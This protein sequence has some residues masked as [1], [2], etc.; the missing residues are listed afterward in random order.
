MFVGRH[1]WIVAEWHRTE[2]D[3]ENTW[4][5]GSPNSSKPSVDDEWASDVCDPFVMLV[6]ES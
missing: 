1:L 3:E 4:G 6:R 2:K 5:H